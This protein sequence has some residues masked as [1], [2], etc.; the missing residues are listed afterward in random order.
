[1]NLF[2]QKIDK[3][4]KT[5]EFRILISLRGQKGLAKTIE[6]RNLIKR[7]LGLNIFG[8]TNVL[9]ELHSNLRRNKN[10]LLTEL[11]HKKAML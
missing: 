3:T 5:V 2:P 11:C 4:E 1:M 9:M 8:K 10:V 6:K 7:N